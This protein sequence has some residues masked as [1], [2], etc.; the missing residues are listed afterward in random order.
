MRHAISTPTAYG[1]TAS[2]VASTPPIGSP[3]PTCASG[4]SAPA[5]ATGS[6]PA[7]RIRVSASASM[8][9]PQTL[10]GASVMTRSIPFT[11]F[12]RSGTLQPMSRALTAVLGVADHGGWAICV[13]VAANRGA[14]AIVDRRRIAL[15]ESGV[16]SQPYHHDTVRM[17]LAQAE[18]LVARVRKSVLRT[19]LASV[20][21]LRDELQ[22]PYTIVA[23]TLRNPPLDYVP[24]TVAEA[25]ASY[26]VMCRADGIMYHDAI[27]QAAKQL[28]IPVERHDRG[29]EIARTAERLDV[30]TEDV[31][32][33]LQRAGKALGSPWQKEHRLA[34]AAAIRVLA[35]RGRA[36]LVI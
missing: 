30:S 6:L 1:I 12:A 28:K 14:P 11:S 8:S 15:I 9:S 26:S 10:Y 18:E 27:C 21:A 7:L 2:C 24:I 3:Y 16:P 25:H 23:M 13:T 19:T 34:A 32:R 5:A 17:P 20:T 33:F 36:S 22:P 31:E 4:M 29:S 35:D